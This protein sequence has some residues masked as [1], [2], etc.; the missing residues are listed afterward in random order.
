MSGILNSVLEQLASIKNDMSNQSSLSLQTLSGTG[1]A[2][3]PRGA[4]GVLEA[5]TCHSS[6]RGA[7]E[8]EG[9]LAY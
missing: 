8:Y 3:L 1:L 7:R 2:L 9:F 4:G 5:R 6:R